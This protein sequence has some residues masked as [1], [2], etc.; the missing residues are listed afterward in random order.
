MNYYP[1]TLEGAKAVLRLRELNAAALRTNTLINEEDQEAWWYNATRKDANQ[2]WWEIRSFRDVLGY[3]GIEHIDEMSLLIDGI[4]ADWSD[5]FDH[6]LNFA[7]NELNLREVHAEVYHC[8]PDRE[9]WLNVAKVFRVEPITLPMR[10][11]CGGRYWDGDYLSW[12]L[13][14]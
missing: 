3:M 5:A 13:P 9:R 14:S 10:K 7:F 1:L 8:S 2:R 11:F 4:D 6:L 12:R